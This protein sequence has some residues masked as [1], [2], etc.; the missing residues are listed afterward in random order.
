MTQVVEHLPS[1]KEAQVQTHPPG[2]QSLVINLN[3]TDVERQ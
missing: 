2:P 1:K 3:A